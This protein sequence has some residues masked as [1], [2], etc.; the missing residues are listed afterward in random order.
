MAKVQ[1]ERPVNL[2]QTLGAAIPAKK[3]A[4]KADAHDPRPELDHVALT[5]VATT[6]GQA[7]QTASR[8]KGVPDA[9]VKYRQALRE[10]LRTGADYKGAEKIYADSG[11]AAKELA[12]IASEEGSSFFRMA[13]DE[14]V[15]AADEHETFAERI[16]KQGGKIRPQLEIRLEALKRQAHTSFDGA[17][18]ADSMLGG[19]DPQRGRD[20]EAMEAILLRMGFP[21]D[22]VAIS[23]RQ[24]PVAAVKQ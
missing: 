20:L 18:R 22:Q 17:V 13:K 21:K 1:G 9:E 6:D 23:S 14:F 16:A 24:R 11:V 19:L 2:I 4:A 15:R 8:A 5:G 10:F 7:V 3:V 12:K